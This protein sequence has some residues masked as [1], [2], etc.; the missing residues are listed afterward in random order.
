MSGGFIPPHPLDNPCSFLLLNSALPSGEQ[1]SVYRGTLDGES[2]IVAKLY[3]RC[4]F[5][6]L[7]REVDAYG[8]LMSSSA[9]PKFLGV[10]GPLHSAWAALILEDKGEPLAARWQ[11]LGHDDRQVFIRFFCFFLF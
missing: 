8:C 3:D 11:D 5:D 2:P 1:A 7:I 10:Y 6:A 4:Y 9:V